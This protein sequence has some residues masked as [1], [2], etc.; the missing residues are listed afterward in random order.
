MDEE[1]LRA[2][3][4]NLKPFAWCLSALFLTGFEAFGSTRLGCACALLASRR[5][6]RAAAPG[7]AQMGRGKAGGG[8]KK[9]VVCR[10]SPV[11]GAPPELWKAVPPSVQEH[12]SVFAAGDF[13]AHLRTQSHREEAAAAAPSAS[14]A[15]V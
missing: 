2:G 14:G 9:T 7:V 13:G 6:L 3:G 1:F 12:N 15:P 4:G 8:P 11:P 10:S 5:A